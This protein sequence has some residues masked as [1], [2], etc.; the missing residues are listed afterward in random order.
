MKKTLGIIGGMG[1]LAT[2]DLFRKIVE[3]TEAAC[4]QEHIHILID[5]NTNIPDRTKALLEGGADPTE[6]LQKSAKRLIAAGAEGLMMPCNTAHNFYEAVRSVSDVPVLHMID[7]TRDSL[8]EK[9]VT[10]AGLLATTGTF[11]TGIYQSRFAGQIELLT[12]NEEE[13]EA[14]MDMIYGGVKAG[15]MDYDASRVQKTAEKLIA[16]GAQTIILGC[17]ELPLAM[18]LYELDFPATD[19]TLELAKGAIRFA[20]GKVKGE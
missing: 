11:R 17:T 8:K 3:H 2:A 5:N 13:Q 4:D 6:E 18:D 12:P 7:L 10:C 14:V 19:P 15:V 9:G 1:P 20:G 16:Q